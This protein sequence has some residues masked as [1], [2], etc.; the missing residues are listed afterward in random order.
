MKILCVSIL[1]AFIV[2]GH[3]CVTR[4]LPHNTCILLMD[5]QSV[6]CQSIDGFLNYENDTIRVTHVFWAERGVMGLLVHNKLKQ[7][8]YVDWRKCSYI[9]GT[10]KHDYWEEGVTM[11][12]TG[13]S[14]TTSRIS[15]QSQTTTSG[16]W[17]YFHSPHIYSEPNSSGE[18]SALSKSVSHSQSSSLGYSN[19]FWASITYITKPERIT[20]IP[21]GTT[22]SIAMY[23][24]FEKDDREIQSMH[25]LSKDTTLVLDQTVKVPLK[26]KNNS[27]GYI[28]VDSTVF[29]PQ[30]VK[31][32]F[33]EFEREASP[34]SFRSFITYS[35]DEKFSTE[36]YVNS[37]FY[38]AR[39]TQI[40]VTV[41]NA[42]KPG[43]PTNESNWNIW[44]T[45][46]S[47][48]VYGTGM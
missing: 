37:S 26:L 3:G 20:F 23:T 4:K 5:I 22:I 19:A 41:F 31:L 28:M 7:P 13:S 47:F 27:V 24:L 36:A 43:A 8:L 38:V 40:P 17:K 30:Q 45:P 33:I 34:L 46:S 6:D 10:A 48:Y 35:T 32:L 12:T 25:F 15:S 11:V 1:I 44:A 18:Q 39:I 21:P 14:I 29:G 9:T 42:K 2:A 16:S